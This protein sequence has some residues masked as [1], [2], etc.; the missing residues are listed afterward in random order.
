MYNQFGSKI[1]ELREA[2]KLYLRQVAPM[3]EMDTAQLS[4]IEKGLRQLKKEQIPILAKVLKADQKELE[5]LWLADQ[6][7]Q[8][9]KDEPTADEALKTVSKY[10]KNR[11]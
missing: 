10:V 7:M 4:K 5:T 8:L 3:L 11:K 6:L 2:Q 9:V 1:R